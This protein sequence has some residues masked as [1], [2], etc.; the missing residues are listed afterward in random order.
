MLDPK[1][2]PGKPMIFLFVGPQHIEELRNLINW[3]KMA[4]H[5][6]FF[7]QKVEGEICLR[8][9]RLLTCGMMASYTL[10]HN[11]LGISDEEI[12]EAYLQSKKEA[13]GCDGKYEVPT[14]M[15]E[16]LQRCIAWN[17]F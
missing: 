15:Y 4:N 3:Q 11:Y 8:M 12:K 16:K 7:L 17:M 13:R 10:N 6:I 1:I 9:G 2:P 5:Y 14:W